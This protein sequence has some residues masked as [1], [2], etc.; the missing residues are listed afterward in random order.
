M[1]VSFHLALLLALALAIGFITLLVKLGTLRK[2]LGYDAF[3]DVIGTLAFA[4]MMS[5][6][7]GGLVVAIMAGTF[8]SIILLILKRAIGYERWFPRRGWVRFPGRL[9][10]AFD[11]WARRQKDPEA[12]FAHHHRRT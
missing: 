12:F 3:V 7:L 1:V 4:W 5:G 6:T 11:A 2:V 9:S 8:L 10:T